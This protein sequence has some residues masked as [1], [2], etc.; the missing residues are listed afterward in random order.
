MKYNNLLVLIILIIFSSCQEKSIEKPIYTT[1]K[2]ENPEWENP[3]VFQINREKPTASFYKYTDESLALKNE[4]WQNSSFLSDITIQKNYR[5][6]TQGTSK[7]LRKHLSL[8][9]LW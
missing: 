1:E 7:R 2:W 9:F 4:S 5:K 6:R 8:C 3:E